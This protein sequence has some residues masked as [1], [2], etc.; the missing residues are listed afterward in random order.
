LTL[1]SAA[2]PIGRRDLVPRV[3]QL[4]DGWRKIRC[5]PAY[6]AGNARARRRG[7]GLLVDHALGQ[8]GLAFVNSAA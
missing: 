3:E 4:T 5:R 8:F 1:R 6:S 7:G 2:E